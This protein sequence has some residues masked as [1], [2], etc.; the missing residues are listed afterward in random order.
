MKSW[1][2]ILLILTIISEII[3]VPSRKSALETKRQN[4]GRR[5]NKLQGITFW[6]SEASQIVLNLK[7]KIQEAYDKVFWKVAG[8]FDGKQSYTWKVFGKSI[9][10]VIPRMPRSWKEFKG[11]LASIE[12]VI[13]DNSRIRYLAAI[14][15]NIAVFVITYIIIFI[16]NIHCYFRYRQVWA[17]NKNDELIFKPTCTTDIFSDLQS[18]LTTARNR[19]DDEQICANAL[20]SPS[21]TILEDDQETDNRI[22]A[23]TLVQRI[24]ARNC[25][26]RTNLSI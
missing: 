6:K 20:S 21:E 10:I 15:A 7:R 16:Y 19:L 3:A 8:F 17:A 4:S 1:V 25:T 18:Y 22:L 9:R 23:N 5:K 24:L 11:R 13:R 26:Q 2:W 14:Y 12:R